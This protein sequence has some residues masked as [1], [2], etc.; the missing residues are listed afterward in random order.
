MKSAVVRNIKAIASRKHAAILTYHGVH[1]EPLPFKL[2]TQLSAVAFEEQMA[3]L[4]KHFNCVAFSKL[5]QY[6][7]ERALPPRTVVITFDDGFL[8]NYTT[9]YPILEKYGLPAT[10]FLSAGFIG[11]DRIIWSERLACIVSLLRDETFSYRD[12]VFSIADVAERSRLFRVIAGDLKQHHHH[13]IDDHIEQLMRDADLSLKDVNASTMYHNLR[14]MNWAQ[15]SELV[16]GGLIEIGA[17]TVNHT[18]L[19]RLSEQ[20]AE[21]EISRSKD[22]IEHHV[23]DVPYFAYPNGGVADYGQEHRCMAER[24]GFKAVVNA[25]LGTV[26]VNSDP[27]DLHRLSIGSDCSLKEFDYLLNGGALFHKNASMLNIIRHLF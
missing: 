19:S 27:Y 22:I 1:S 10:I 15:I 25:M 2:W 6:L 24:A 18:I 17:H 4:A 3:H 9:A 5:L 16:S 7:E 11:T 8:N 23:N 20:E 26:T 13:I 12:Q 21:D 14:L